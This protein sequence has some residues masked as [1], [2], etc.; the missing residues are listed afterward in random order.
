MKETRGSVRSIEAVFS[1]ITSLRHQT[2]SLL[3]DRLYGMVYIER[4]GLGL[5]GGRGDWMEDRGYR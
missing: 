3:V 1:V 4:M 2:C 5:G